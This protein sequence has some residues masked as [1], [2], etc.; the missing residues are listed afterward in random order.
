MPAGYKVDHV[1]KKLNSAFVSFDNKDRRIDLIIGT[2]Y[3]ADHLEGLVPILEDSTIAVGHVWLPPV[4]NDVDGQA[5]D[6]PIADHH[7]LVWQFA[8]DEGEAILDRYLDAKR[9]EIEELCEI[10][11]PELPGRDWTRH[12]DRQEVESDEVRQGSDQR[13]LGPERAERVANLRR[14]LEM[15]LHQLGD[16]EPHGNP[17]IEEELSQAVASRE[18]VRRY[19][20]YPDA[21]PFGHLEE[22]DGKERITLARELLDRA[23][24]LAMAQRR[25]LAHIRKAAVKDAIN[26]ASLYKVVVA[27]KQRKPPITPQS[28]FIEDGVPR[29]FVWQRNS[30]RFIGA[31]ELASDGPVLTLLGPS[32]SLVRKHRN[33]LP[34]GTYLA[35]ALAFRM[36]VKTITPSNQLSYVVRIEHGGQGILVAG[37]AGFVDFKRGRRQYHQALLN[38]L[39]PLHVIQI[40]HHGGANAHF[41]HVLAAA[42]FPEQTDHAFLLLSHATKDVYRPSREFRLF[43]EKVRRVGD[44]VSILFTSEPRH[45]K[46][47]GFVDLIAPATALRKDRGD[48]QMLFTKGAW[49]VKQHLIAI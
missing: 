24:A 49:T 30:G 28:E 22:L 39:L 10:S 31:R 34:R 38:A 13:L 26:A 9:D 19:Y 44:D 2:H 18:R 40:A 41:Y 37:D 17:P 25:T 27:A 1:H 20:R 6:T 48:I 42:D 4:A 12:F 5:V 21:Y 23:P 36:E 7:L 29:R 8:S 46:V 16:E 14:Y 35:N 47:A 32:K 11:D 43:V 15:L 3:D 33:R 45:E